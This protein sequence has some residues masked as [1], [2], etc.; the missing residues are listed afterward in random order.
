MRFSTLLTTA[1]LWTSVA[2]AARLPNGLDVEAVRRLGLVVG[3]PMSAR[4]LRSAETLDVWPGIKAGV[5][6]PMALTNASNDVGNGN[7]VPEAL[8]LVPRLFLA[9]GLPW[10]T[11]ISLSFA[12]AVSPTGNASFGTTVKV[13][14]ADEREGWGSAAAFGGFTRVDAFRGD[15]RSTNV[16]VGVIASKDYVRLR[17]FVGAGT[18][19]VFGEVAPGLA[20]GAPAATA[21]VLHTFLGTEIEYPANFTVQIDFYNTRPGFSAFVGYRW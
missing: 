5:E 14:F 7:G 20:L 21:A 8:S 16:E 13:Q 15:W 19:L 18:L 17:P 9:K 4:P 12:P 6:V 11:E 1:L 10:G 3:A 2:E